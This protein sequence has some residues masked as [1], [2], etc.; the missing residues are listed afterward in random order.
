MAHIVK[1]ELG[2][3]LYLREQDYKFG[4]GP[5]VCTVTRVINLVRFD[6]LPWWHIEGSCAA[7]TL[8]D[9]GD[10]G[11]RDLYVASSAVPARPQV[12]RQSPPGD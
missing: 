11:D 1:P 3:R 9:H 10:F 6:G 7:G 4:T 8:L 5:V 2:M 12:V